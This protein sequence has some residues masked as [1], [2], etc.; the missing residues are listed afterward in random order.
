MTVMESLKSILYSQNSMSVLQ[1][2]ISKV[3]LSVNTFERG[4]VLQLM[5]DVDRVI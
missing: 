2:L 4:I 5:S 3:N 1:Q